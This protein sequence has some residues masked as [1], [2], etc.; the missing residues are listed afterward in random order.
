MVSN[1]RVAIFA[2]VTLAAIIIASFLLW[3]QQP[4]ASQRTW[5]PVDFINGKGEYETATFQIVNPWRLKW[6]YTKTEHSVFGVYIYKKYEIEWHPI[7]GQSSL[8]T[9][10]T[11]ETI[12]LNYTGT[13]YIKVLA[14]AQTQW[15]LT[16]QEYR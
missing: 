10:A 5:Q 1:R 13:F 7:A 8:E 6:N 2:S 16:I 9:N 4:R 15:K 3:N 11:T 12:T 14:T